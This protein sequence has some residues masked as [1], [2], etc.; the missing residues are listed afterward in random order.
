MPM[1]IASIWGLWSS[2]LPS[3]LDGLVVTMEITGLGLGVAIVFGM[4]LAGCRLSRFRVLR[5]LATIYVDVLR[6]VP[7]LVLLFL[8]YYG[9]GQLGLTLSGIASATV[10]LGAFY[11]ALLCEIFR[12]GIQGVERG[13]RE[14]A[15]ALGLKRTSVFVRV[16]LPQAILL[17]LAPSTNQV[18][19]IIKDSSLVV[20]IGVADL[21]ARSY[22]A[23]S[24]T[25]QPMDM[26]VLAGIIYMVLYVV[27]A[28][29]LGRWERNVQRRYS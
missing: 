24:T 5:L 15:D 28:R 9:L 26:F 18:S 27:L 13:Q 7:V 16:T 1:L 29:V 17:I 20:T 22:E 11:S 8:A 19:N 12:G 10:A 2:Y 4:I 23:S 14:A 6:S 25:F 3:F 21:M